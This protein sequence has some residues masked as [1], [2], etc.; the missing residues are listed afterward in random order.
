MLRS[1]DRTYLM[2]K[3]I[4]FL[5]D[6]V[7]LNL[8]VVFV[9]NILDTSRSFTL[10]YRLIFETVKNEYG[11]HHCCKTFRWIQNSCFAVLIHYQIM[12]CAALLEAAILFIEKRKKKKNKELSTNSIELLLVNILFFIA[13]NCSSVIN[14]GNEKKNGLYR[15][16]ANHV[17]KSNC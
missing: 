5:L 2:N 11:Y 15:Q 6:V 13:Q 16:Q 7:V 8:F 12:S 10:C 3:S 9:K 1:N 14:G 4:R 17:K